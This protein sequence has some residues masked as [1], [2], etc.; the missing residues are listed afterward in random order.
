[1]TS[2]TSIEALVCIG[3]IVIAV[4]ALALVIKER[5]EAMPAGWHTEVSYGKE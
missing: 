3:C 2:D 4:L 1:M 5:N